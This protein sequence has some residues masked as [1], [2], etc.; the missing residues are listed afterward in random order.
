MMLLHVVAPL[1]LLSLIS[2]VTPSLLGL[3]LPPSPP[4]RVV[5]PPEKWFPQTLDHFHPADGRR[6][7]QRYWYNM[8]HYQE[9]GPTFIMIGGEAVANPRWLNY[10]TWLTFAKEQGAAMFLLEHRFYGESHPT[11]DM[12]VENLVYL[13]SHQGLADLADFIV[14]M[15]SEHGLTGPWIST[16]GSYP[17]SM[18]AWL[19]YRYPHLVA[20]AISSSGPLLAKIDFHEYFEVILN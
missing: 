17:G 14:A 3:R 19:R 20:G 18:S 16:G 6:W 7:Q 1:L 10:G 15:K 4:A 5:A 9:G 8:D 13:T 11:E 12:S 2:T